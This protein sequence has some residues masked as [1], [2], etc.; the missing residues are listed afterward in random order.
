MKTFKKYWQFIALAALMFV[1]LLA[2]MATRNS[3]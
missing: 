3:L 1:W 2:E